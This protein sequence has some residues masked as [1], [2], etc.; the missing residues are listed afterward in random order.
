[1]RKKGLL[2]AFRNSEFRMDGKECLRFDGKLGELVLGV[3]SVFVCAAEPAQSGRGAHTRNLGNLLLV[4]HRQILG[5][6][7][8]VVDH[9]SHCLSRCGIPAIEQAPVKCQEHPE[10]AK[11][12]S[13]TR[14]GQSCATAIAH[15]ISNYKRQAR[16]HCVISRSE[17][18]PSLPFIYTYY[19]INMQA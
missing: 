15:R 10:Q 9:Q 7:N 18:E 8:P 6:G 19:M 4:G 1:M 3:A 14:N 11:R 12:Y 16:E 5:E 2:L 13:D 17:R